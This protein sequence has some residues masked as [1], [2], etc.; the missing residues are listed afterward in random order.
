MR[1]PG[2]LSYL[3]AEDLSL[4]KRRCQPGAPLTWK[5]WEEA[6]SKGI[7]VVGRTQFLVAIGMRF[8]FPCK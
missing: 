6:T 8:P 2:G 5:L 7:Q 3:P 4:L 1:S